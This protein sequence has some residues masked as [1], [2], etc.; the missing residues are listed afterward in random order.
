MTV[1]FSDDDRGR[2]R[3]RHRVSDDGLIRATSV[4]MII[5]VRPRRIVMTGRLSDFR[6]ADVMQA[7]G[8]SRQFTEIELRGPGG[9]LRGTVWLKD[10]RV[11]AAEYDGQRGRPAFRDV[12]GATT[13]VFVVA[14]LPDPEAYP[15]ALGALGALLVE[16]ADA[17]T[18]T[19]RLE[20]S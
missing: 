8:W 14:R 6:L 1:R 13:D 2:I 3:E 19:P 16:A 20:P 18:P 15:T 4:R 17:L 9:R 7:V 10:G 11:L 5:D 12:L